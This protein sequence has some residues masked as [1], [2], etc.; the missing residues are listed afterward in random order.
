MGDE[1][2]ERLDRRQMKGAVDRAIV[3]DH[4]DPGMPVLVHPDPEV[5]RLNRA[6]AIEM[7]DPFFRGL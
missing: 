7:V 6:E 4:R 3:S 5:V 1:F 2:R